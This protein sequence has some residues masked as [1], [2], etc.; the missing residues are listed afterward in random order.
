LA[1]IPEEF[2]DEI[3]KDRIESLDKEIASIKE[4]L[5]RRKI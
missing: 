3:L 4:I 5:M 2:A 1:S